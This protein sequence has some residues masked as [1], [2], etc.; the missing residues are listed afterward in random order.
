MAR[1]DKQRLR[2]DA[3][4]RQKVL[5]DMAV[6]AKSRW[7]YAKLKT[8]FYI[9]IAVFVFTAGI[10]LGGRLTPRQADWVTLGFVCL[11]IV[12]M[13]GWMLVSVHNHQKKTGES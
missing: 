12:P 13:M 8:S 9:L 7:F 6:A 3:E 11:F 4:Y 1:Y 10:F 2:D 5:D